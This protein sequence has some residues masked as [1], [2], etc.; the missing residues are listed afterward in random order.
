MSRLIFF[1]SMLIFSITGSSVLSQK[2][3]S[4]KSTTISQK[5]N[6]FS[7]TAKDDFSPLQFFMIIVVI[8]FILI[9]LGV[10]IVLTIIGLL[11]IFGL[12][13][14]GVLSASLIVGMHKKSFLKGFKVFLFSVT[15]FG[16]VIFGSVSFWILNN[17]SHWWTGKVALITGSLSG[18]LAGLLL[19]FVVLFILKRLTVLFKTKIQE[20]TC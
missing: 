16:G 18:F 19:G 7:T 9:C 20:T 4:I 10:G 14:I 2:S 6:D 11:I 15:S 17:L 8:A 3:D 13:G 12:V 1:I 5:E